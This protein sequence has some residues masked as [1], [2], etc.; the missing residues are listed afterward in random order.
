MPAS[1][2]LFVGDQIDPATGSS[3]R[4]GSFR[5]PDEDVYFFV[6]ENVGKYFV[7]PSGGYF[8]Q[9]GALMANGMEY[10]KGIPVGQFFTEVAQAGS[11]ICPEEEAAEW[12][13]VHSV[14]SPALPE[15]SDGGK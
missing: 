2:E 9:Q 6:V 13:R 1:V 5:R 3:D 11:T 7:H 14:Q 12:V 10:K 15:S 8:W 4:F